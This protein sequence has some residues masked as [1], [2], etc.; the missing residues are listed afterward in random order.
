MLQL[1]LT[2]LSDSRRRGKTVRISEFRRHEFDECPTC[3]Q[4]P[5]PGSNQYVHYR[6]AFNYELSLF[7]VKNLCYIFMLCHSLYP[8]EK[9]N[10]A[11]LLSIRFPAHKSF[12]MN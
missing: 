7:V 6:A 3:I 11:M 9:Q 2:L 5:P 10:Y 1:P 8:G 12:H 4:L